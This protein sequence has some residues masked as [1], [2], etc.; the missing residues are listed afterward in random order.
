[1]DTSRNDTFVS[2]VDIMAVSD[3]DE[4]L[5]G[6]NCDKIAAELT[7]YSP[8]ETNANEMKENKLTNE[9]TIACGAARQGGE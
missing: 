7:K 4:A 5:N 9:N 1:M 3:D 8:H 6:P 2:A